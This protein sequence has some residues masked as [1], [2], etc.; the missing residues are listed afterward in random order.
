MRKVFNSQFKITQEFGVN[1][2]YYSQFGLQGHEGIDLIPT[3][4]VWDV[5]ALEDGVVVLDDDVVGSVS[6][7]PYGKRVTLWHP[8]IKK[9]TN[10][11]HLAENYVVM[12][13][14]VKR[15]EKI[16]LMGSTGNSTGPHLHL[17]LFEVDDQGIRLNKNNG[18][19]G[20]INPKP[21]L[22]ESVADNSEPTVTLPQKEVDQ[23]RL[24][25]DTHYNNLQEEKKKNTQLTS[26]LLKEQEHSGE[27]LRQLEKIS[28]EERSTTGQLLDAQKAV[29]PLQDVILGVQKELNLIDGADKQTMLK[30]IEILKEFKVIKE[31]VPIPFVARLKYCLNLLFS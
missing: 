28:D 22:E 15:G 10:Y 18:F 13:Q 30:A 21:F 19:L 12:G 17:N 24:D 1:K 2:E 25:R 5:Y 23:M 8:N 14:Q 27:L 20:G 7:D 4:S 3:G 11:N 26:D 31:E 29:K 16:G 9:A 6:S